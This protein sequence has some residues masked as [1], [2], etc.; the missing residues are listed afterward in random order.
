M[1]CIH[2]ID[3]RIV[4]SVTPVSAAARRSA[5]ARVASPRGATR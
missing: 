4:N 3:A 5:I 1:P 2:V